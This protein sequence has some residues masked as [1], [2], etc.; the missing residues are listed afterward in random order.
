M[1]D[2]VTLKKAKNKKLKIVSTYVAECKAELLLKV[3]QFKQTDY[4]KYNLIQ[5]NASSV[6]C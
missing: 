3:S 2:R 5:W 4:M 1:S 6:N